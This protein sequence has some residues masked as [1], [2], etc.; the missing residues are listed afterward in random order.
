MEILDGQTSSDILNGTA[1]KSWL[2][3]AIKFVDET[4]QK[5]GLWIDG[6]TING[7]RL[8]DWYRA[9]PLSA[10]A[11]VIG[12]G[13]VAYAAGSAIASLIGTGA[14]VLALVRS[15]G[16]GGALRA[17][18]GMAARG[19]QSGLVWILGHPG[20]FATRFIAGITAGAVLR[21]CVGGAIKL[22]NIDWNA[23]DKELD[24]QVKSAQDGLWGVAGASLGTLL[25]NTACGIVPGA[26]VVRVNPAKLAAIKEVNEELYEEIMPAVNNLVMA[27]VMV[28][29]VKSFT[30]IYKNTRRWIKS[31]SEFL[32]NYSPFWADV[33]KAW[34][35]ENSRP[36]TINGAIEEIIESIPDSGIKA[37]AQNAWES[38]IESC[39][40]ALMVFSTAFG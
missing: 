11:G 3:T 21:W 33:V 4:T 38:T 31:K 6:L 30:E 28:T 37:F 14:S 32:R 12:V 8:G 25:G 18:G 7:V 17:A 35:E 24:N 22:I 1:D 5:I 40:E 20:A 39:A 36:W 2:D 19:L 9:D 26:A 10:T 13:V 29:R 16:L 15:V 23:T 27:S 34:G